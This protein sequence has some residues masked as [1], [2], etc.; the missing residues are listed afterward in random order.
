MKLFFRYTFIAIGTIAVLILLWASI[1]KLYNFHTV[2]LQP[3]LFNTNSIEY[4]YLNHLLLGYLHIIPGIIFLVLGAYQF[5]PYFRNNYRK[6]HRFIGK[7]FLFLAAIIFITAIVLAV[8]V[9]FGNWL[10]TIVTIVFG[11]YLLYG[12]Y[13]AYLCKSKKNQIASKM[14]NQGIFY[15]HCCFND[16][17]CN[18]PV[19]VFC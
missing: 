14:G 15:C 5:I 12:T 1:I 3:E 2:S 4:H 16:K 7:V 13:K 6:L 10:E 19:Y 11:I 17:G 18:C 8:F 9:P